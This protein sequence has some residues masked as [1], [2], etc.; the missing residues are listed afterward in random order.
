M[1]D[2][3]QLDIRLPMGVL[4]IVFGLVLAGYGLSTE[5]V[6]HAGYKPPVNIDLWWGLLLL[7]FGGI[8]SLWAVLAAPKAP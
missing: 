3:V 8:S 5:P 7:V 6:T 4:F 1:H 2:N